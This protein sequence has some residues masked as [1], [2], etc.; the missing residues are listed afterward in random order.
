MVGR[1]LIRGRVMEEI[2]SSVAKVGLAVDRFHNHLGMDT[3]NW[4]L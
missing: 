2:C 1:T 3:L 4:T